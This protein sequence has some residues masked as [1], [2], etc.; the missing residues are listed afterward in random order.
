MNNNEIQESRKLFGQALAEALA[1]KYDEELKEA[2]DVKLP[3]DHDVTGTPLCP[4]HPKICLGNGIFPG[5]ECC[6]DECDY[7]LQC[8]PEWDSGGSAWKEI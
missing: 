1:E 2:P 4:G 6:C 3:V 5:F 7:F 8:F